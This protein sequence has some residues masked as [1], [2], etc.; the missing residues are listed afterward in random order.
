MD[1]F[2]HPFTNE[3][4]IRLEMDYDKPF[5]VSKRSLA[6]TLEAVSTDDP[7]ENDHSRPSIH[8]IKDPRKKAKLAMQK[9][10]LEEIGD[11]EL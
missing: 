11:M 8:D 4:C 2:N 6:S 9:A 5:S 7:F 1:Y 10:G 3:K